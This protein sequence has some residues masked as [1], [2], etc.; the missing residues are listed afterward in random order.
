MG[1]ETSRRSEPAMDEFLELGTFDERAGAVARAT[2]RGAPR[3]WVP[4]AAN[5]VFVTCAS[6]AHLVGEAELASGIA[7]AFARSPMVTAYAAWHVNE[8]ARGRFVLGLGPQVKA[9]ITRRYGMP[10]SSP[11]AR[12]SEYVQAA[13]RSG[14][15]GRTA[16]RCI[17]R[18]VLRAHAHATP[19]R[20]RPL[21]LR[22]A[23]DRRRR[24]G[25][26]DAPGRWGGRRWRDHPQPADRTHDRVDHAA[27][28]QP[29]LRARQ[30]DRSSFEITNEVMVAS[31]DT[32]AESSAAC[33]AAKAAIACYGSTP[34]Y[35]RVLEAE[36]LGGL[37]A[38]LRVASQ[39]GRWAEMGS[40]ISDDVLGALRGDG[41]PG[42]GAR[43]R[44]GAVGVGRPR[45]HPSTVR[46]DMN[47]ISL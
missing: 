17:P 27:G 47:E 8:L 41:Q 42:R 19:V 4:E 2:G 12:M 11:A 30:F 10:W 20:S 22:R 39:E 16:R 45:D 18:R 33:E 9:N 46:S 40:M 21:P 26:T 14:A 29:G 13:V 23:A 7:I 36:N 15:R 3:L 24:R 28:A 6:L 35:S 1:A 31:G 43:S 44:G 38:Q 25:P 5:D 37:H 32:P 34:A